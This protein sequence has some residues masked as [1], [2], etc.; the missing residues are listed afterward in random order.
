LLDG[1]PPVAV[2][3][4][5]IDNSRHGR[6]QRWPA[7]PDRKIQRL[8]SQLL[9]LCGSVKTVLSFRKSSVFSRTRFQYCHCHIKYI[10]VIASG[11]V[12]AAEV[13]V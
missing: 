10:Q 7:V 4:G 12:I 13:R 1:T 6:R 9:S 11:G 3:R 2:G 8:F 5:A